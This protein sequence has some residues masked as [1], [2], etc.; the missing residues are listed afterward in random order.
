M[1]VD[2]EQQLRE[3]IWL[4]FTDIWWPICKSFRVLL[5]RSYS[6]SDNHPK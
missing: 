6:N 3:S 1:Q 2:K 5:G 4:L